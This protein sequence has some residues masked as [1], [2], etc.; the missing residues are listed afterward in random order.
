MV[1]R[2]LKKHPEVNALVDGNQIKT[3]ENINVAVAVDTSDGLKVPVIRDADRLTIKDIVM[4]LRQLIDRA[5]NGQL[6]IDEMRGGTF[7]ISNLGMFGVEGFTPIINP[8][9]CAILGMGSIVEKP[10][11]VEGQVSIGKMMTLSLSFDHRVMDGVTAANFV[12]TLKAIV[13]NK[14]D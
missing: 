12:G 11:A 4:T 1:A 9:Q 6:R 7:T 8:P 5:K 14:E 10:I 2:A 13:S 3:I